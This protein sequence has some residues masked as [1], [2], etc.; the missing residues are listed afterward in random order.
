[1]NEGSTDGIKGEESVFS[2]RIGARVREIRRG[3]GLTLDELAEGARAS[4]AM[5]SKLERGEKNPTLVVAARVAEGL[6]VT[7]TQLIETE[8]RSAVVV[9]PRG[10]RRVMR[11]PMTGFERQAISPDTSGRGVEFVYNVVPE[12]SSSGEFPPHRAGVRS[13]SWSI[14]GDCER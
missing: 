12:G 1:M 2:E 5:L 13:T 11:D 8:Q 3:A 7:L 10:G 4:R 14:E 6:S 9:I